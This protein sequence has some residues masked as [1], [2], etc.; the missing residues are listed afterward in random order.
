MDKKY[1]QTAVVIFVL[2]M[3]FL[4]I[5][6]RLGARQ[7]LPSLDAALKNITYSEKDIKIN[8]DVAAF[9]VTRAKDPMQMGPQAAKLVMGSVPAGLTALTT[10]G[11]NVVLQGIFWRPGD[12]P[13]AIISGKIVMAGDFVGNAQ[14]VEITRTGVRLLTE[15]REELLSLHS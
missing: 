2:F 15:G 7:V 5:L 13:K 3:I 1:T 14:V 10:D 12:V 4:A 9:S 6:D 11:G 8:G